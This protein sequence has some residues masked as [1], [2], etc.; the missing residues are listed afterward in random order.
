[1]FVSLTAVAFYA[2]LSKTIEK[3]KIGHVIAFDNV[4]TN[5]GGAYDAST[6]KFTTPISGHYVFSWTTVCT[7]GTLIGTLLKW[8]GKPTGSAQDDCRD[9]NGSGSNTAILKL[10]KGDVVDIS[11]HGSAKYPR[12]AYGNGYSTIS[13]YLIP[14]VNQGDSTGKQS[15]KRHRQECNTARLPRFISS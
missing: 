4:L 6:G 11:V 8:N 12:Q 2:R 10:A 1:M 3:G 13:G 5:T 15:T 7:T 14:Y 9:Q